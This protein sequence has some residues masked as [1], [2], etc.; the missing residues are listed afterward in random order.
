MGE[1]S[2]R[3]TD[4]CFP[5]P[6]ERIRW[7]IFIPEETRILKTDSDFHRCPFFHLVLFLFILFLLF[8]PSAHTERFRRTSRSFQSGM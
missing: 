2:G 7:E 5:F 3:Q 8:P 6:P 1:G 4:V